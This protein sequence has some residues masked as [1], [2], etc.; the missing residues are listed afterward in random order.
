MD[1]YKFTDIFQE[2]LD[3]SLSPKVRI[4]INGME[5]GPEVSF[6]RGVSFGGVNLYQYKNLDIAA[7]TQEGILII[8]GFFK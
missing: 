1:R 5:F 2:N 8:G 4:S 7:E 3:G 6:N